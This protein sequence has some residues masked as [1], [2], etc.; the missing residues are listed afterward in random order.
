MSPLLVAAVLWSSAEAA[1]PAQPNE[2]VQ[3]E[4]AAVIEYRHQAFQGMGKHLKAVSMAAKGRVTLPQKD[5]LLHTKALARAAQL[6]P[7]WFPPGTGAAKESKSD[8]LS[9]IW[10]NASGFQ[11]AAGAFQTATKALVA[12]AEAGEADGL[13]P[14]VK[15]VGASCGGCH[16]AFR[17]DDER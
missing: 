16:D 5:L 13:L 15:K 14:A 6:L 3:G 2:A 8:A 12:V 11:E 17:K 7:G 1:D 9:A 10:T 4:P